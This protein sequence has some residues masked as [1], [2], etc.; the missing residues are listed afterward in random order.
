MRSSAFY[1]KTT[2][3]KSKE[4]GVREFERCTERKKLNSEQRAHSAH[5]IHL[6]A[7]RHIE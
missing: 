5:I 1:K 7:E 2:T 3:N 4:L 6:A